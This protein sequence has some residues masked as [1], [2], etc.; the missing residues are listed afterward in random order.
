[1]I[2]SMLSYSLDIIQLTV[3][4]AADR[5]EGGNRGIFPWAPL[6]LKCP[7]QAACEC[8][9]CFEVFIYKS[10]GICFPYVILD[11]ELLCL[12]IE[13]TRCRMI[14]YAVVLRVLL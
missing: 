7:Q 11:P 14:V 8:S 2:I 10:V 4:R 12:V 5:G 13:H 9:P 1:M 3:C 6:Y